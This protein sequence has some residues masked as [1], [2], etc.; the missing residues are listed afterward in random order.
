MYDNPIYRWRESLAIALSR[1]Q[2]KPLHGYLAYGSISN[3]LNQHGLAIFG[4]EARP[5][6]TDEERSALI[7]DGARME[8]LIGEARQVPIDP[9]LPPVTSPWQRKR[10]GRLLLFCV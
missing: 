9:S 7:H 5:V 1:M 8:K 2:A 6:P 3:Y 4:S 10:F